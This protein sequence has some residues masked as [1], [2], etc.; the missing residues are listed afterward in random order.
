MELELLQGM[1][2]SRAAKLR[3]AG[4][5]DLV[6]LAELDLRRSAPDGMN[7]DSLRKWKGQAR[8]LLDAEGVAYQKAPYRSNGAPATTPKPDAPQ[9]EPVLQHKTAPPAK[10]G[11][12]A[13]ILGR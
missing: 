11:L 1:G 10:R 2:P 9:A 6:A 4:I 13:R 3:D 5:T 7:A 12:L 8:K